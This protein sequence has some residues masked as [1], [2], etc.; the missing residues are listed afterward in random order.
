MIIKMKIMAIDYGAVRTGIA[1]SDTLGM[2]ASPVCVITEENQKKL[3]Q[4]I[5]ELAKEKN[6]SLL[7]LGLPKNMDGSEGES[8]Q[9]C[10]SLAERLCQKSGLEV[11]LIDERNT[12]KSAALCLNDTNTRGAKRKSVIDA[13]AAT[14]ILQSYLDKA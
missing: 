12:T 14:I 11:K 8:A 3:V 1:L 6:A 10:R 7:I 5:C 2:L 4:K 9:K 13:V